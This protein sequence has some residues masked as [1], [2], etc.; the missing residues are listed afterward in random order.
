MASDNQGKKQHAWQVWLHANFASLVRACVVAIITWTIVQIDPLGLGSASGAEAKRTFQRIL[1]APFYRGAQD[2]I[3]VVLIDDDYLKAVGHGWPLPYAYQGRLLETVL[4]YEPKAV[5][6]DLLYRQKHSAEDTPANLLAPIRNRDIP[7]VLAGMAKLPSAGQV[8]TNCE[9]DRPWSSD[10]AIDK[11]SID[12]ELFDLRT[13]TS[14][15]GFSKLSVAYL[16]WYGCGDRYPLYLSGNPKLKTPAY[17]LYDLT[18]SEENRNHA[19][20]TEPMTVMWGAVQSEASAALYADD[21]GCEPTSGTGISGALQQVL[22]TIAGI[23]GSGPRG[24]RLA[25]PYTDVVMAS[26]LMQGVKT[27]RS[28][29]NPLLALLEGRYIFIGTSISGVWD[30]V[31]SPVNGSL[32][33]VF[34]HA[35]ALDN[36]LHYNDGYTRILSEWWELAFFLVVALV[37]AAVHVHRKSHKKQEGNDLASRARRLKISATA[38]LLI[39]F[40]IAVL[41]S[42][43]GHPW[44]AVLCV[45][46]GV[47]LDWLRLPM[48]VPMLIAG[49][50]CLGLELLLWAAPFWHWAPF[51]WFSLSAMV[52]LVRKHFEKIDALPAQHKHFSIWHAAAQRYQSSANTRE[53]GT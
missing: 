10:D 52:L 46:A 1:T 44:A 47:G 34:V 15:T 42:Y 35:M 11:D 49:S 3:T 27:G 22:R 8:R 23:A 2:K 14:A 31:E 29:D 21:A 40:G 7:V 24:I 6:L 4:S 19:K 18:R 37:M 39:W 12:P 17:A 36:L 26:Q 50:L 48:F 25:C 32:P 30:L 33:G 51:N 28:A 16:N 38:E 5:F 41:L 9:A 13:G 43:T 45:I 20:F 53:L